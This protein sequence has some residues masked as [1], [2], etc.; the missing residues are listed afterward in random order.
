[1][2]EKLIFGRIFLEKEWFSMFFIKKSEKTRDFELAY[3]TFSAK[4][5]NQAKKILRLFVPY[6]LKGEVCQEFGEK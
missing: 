2:L 5:L 1:M 4:S 3:R 6:S